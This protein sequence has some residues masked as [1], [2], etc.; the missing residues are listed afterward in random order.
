MVSSN[1]LHL[2]FDTFQKYA[3]EYA[4]VIPPIDNTVDK[5]NDSVREAK[6]GWQGDANDAFNTLADKL[7]LEIR[8]VNKNLN[9][10]S[11]ALAAGEKKVATS[12]NESMS[13]FTTLGTNY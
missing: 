6:R 13:G 5:L 2:D 12:D 4:A 9:I 10:V 1:A 8:D 11:E 7:E 3:N